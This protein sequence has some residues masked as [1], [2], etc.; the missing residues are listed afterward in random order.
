M[1]QYIRWSLFIALPVVAMVLNGC[2]KN[3]NQVPQATATNSAV[4]GSTQGLQLYAYSFYD[5][6]PSAATTVR[7]DDQYGNAD[8]GARNAAP[9]YLQDGAFSS[10]QA[11]A[12]G[13]W[14][15]TPLRNL[16]YFIANAVPNPGVPE[17][18]RLNFIGL[19]RFFRAYFYFSMVQKF[20]NVPWVGKPLGVNDSALYA[21]RTDR[22]I[23]M[24]SVLEDVNYA[25]AHISAT[26]D[27]TSST[28]TKW[29]AY[30]LKA[31]ICLYEGTYRRY[32]TDQLVTT[33]MRSEVQTWLQ[34]AASAAKAVMDS[35]GFTL[36]TTGGNTLAYRNLFISTNPVSSEVMLSDVMSQSLAVLNDAN[37]YYT[38]ATYGSRYSFTRD[39][40]KTYLNADGTPFTSIPGNDTLP[41][42]KETKNR[43][44]RLG[45]TIRMGNYTR[46]SSGKTIAAP[47]VFSYTY[48]GYMPIKWSLDDT[49]YD[50]NTTNINSISLMR[51]AE[52][53][54]DYAEATE[55]L[56]NYGGPG[57]SAGDWTKTIGALRSRAG[58]T[59]NLALP[60]VV[61]PYIQQYYSPTDV[62]SPAIPPIADPVLLEIR[63]ERGV[64]LCLEGFRF[65]DLC[66]WRLGDLLQKSWNGMYV[67]ALNVPM[68]LNGDGVPDVLFY[69]GTPPA[70]ISGVTFINVSP[71]VNGTPNPMQ[72]ANGTYGEIHW[73]DNVPRQW[74]DYK[75][76]Y[77]IP[78]SEL[79]L[80][81][82]LQQNQGWQ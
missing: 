50:A 66:R 6:L 31:R 77:P 53:L 26:T 64:E 49:Y 48:T 67:P 19:A 17:A 23:V 76:L 43:D 9:I 29:V 82:N 47:P 39:F 63:R 5:A 41:F 61:D 18:T 45:Q 15:W 58:I 22:V 27:A 8:F 65:A 12:S 7:G 46:I 34:N 14:N 54:L 32:Q 16:N 57:L 69:Q 30:G 20:G 42:V 4:F 52:M 36:N 80:N 13:D 21:A 40:I 71:T 11:T 78:Y 44:G 70:A 81:S 25:I 51:Y 55:E 62:S 79:L 60:T 3:L 2:S 38:S 75:Y 74:H 73:L 56:K 28:I 10:R 35:S 37:W 24:D 72:L 59:A 68:D 33:G 1:R